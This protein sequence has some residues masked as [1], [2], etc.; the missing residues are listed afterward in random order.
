MRGRRSQVRA[1]RVEIEGVYFALSEYS[2][3]FG[4]NDNLTQIN[5]LSATTNTA[6]AQPPPSSS[7]SSVSPSLSTVSTTPLPPSASP[8]ANDVSTSPPPLKKDRMTL[9][10]GDIPNIDTPRAVAPVN[11]NK[12]FSESL[13]QSVKEMQN[14]TVKAGKETPRRGSNGESGKTGQEQRVKREVQEIINTRLKTF[15]D[16]GRFADQESMNHL[17]RHLVNVVAK[18]RIAARKF[19]ISEDGRKRIEEFVDKSMRPN[20]DDSFVYD[21]RQYTKKQ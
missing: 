7:S 1:K 13:T 8:Q 11:A 18:R 3:V 20:N 6:T 14:V 10:F 19:E 17:A 21:Y 15:F 9:F 12:V 4:I 2:D 16:A 5:S